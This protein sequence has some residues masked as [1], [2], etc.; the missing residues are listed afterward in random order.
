MST[1][2]TIQGEEPVMDTFAEAQQRWHPWRRRYDLFLRQTPYRIL[3]KVDE[4]Q[5]EPEPDLFRQFAVIDGGFLAWHF[6]LKDDQGLSIASVN[7]AFRGFGREVSPY[8][9]KWGRRLNATLDL[10]GH[11]YDKE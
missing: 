11:R 2:T 10:H 8:L 5:P 7:R 1:D 4:P 9:L 6:A 3:S